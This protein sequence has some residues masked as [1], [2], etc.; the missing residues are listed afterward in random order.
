MSKYVHNKIQKPLNGALASKM[1]R[2]E[3]L[4]FSAGLIVSLSG[5]GNAIRQMKPTNKSASSFGGGVY[6]GR[7]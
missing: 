3:F 7:K 1:D 5:I 4:M 2:R 6:G